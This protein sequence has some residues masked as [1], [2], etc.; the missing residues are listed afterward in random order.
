MGPWD[1]TFKLHY[2]RGISSAAKSLVDD[3]I[4][5]NEAFVISK[6]YCPFCLKAKFLLSN[7]G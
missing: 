3:G 5:N 4:A 7:A 1:N 2:F 6:S